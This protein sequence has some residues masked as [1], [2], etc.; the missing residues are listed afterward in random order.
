MNIRAMKASDIPKIEAIYRRSPAKYDIPLLDSTMI[1]DSLVMVDENDEPRAMLATEK[2]AEIFLV[3]DHDWETP[4]FLAF[5]LQELAKSLREKMERKGYRSFYAF[6]G[7]DV[8]KSFDRRL[9]QL[10]ARKMLW[11]CVRFG[12]EG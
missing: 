6:L 2:V 1:E 10:G 4:A 7:D 8:P 5:A 12:R 9:F 3:L 11:R